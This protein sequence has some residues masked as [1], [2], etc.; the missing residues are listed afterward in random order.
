MLSAPPPA[1]RQLIRIDGFVPVPPAPHGSEEKVPCPQKAAGSSKQPTKMPSAPRFSASL[2]SFK[3]SA[4]LS[5][6]WV[7]D[8]MVKLPFSDFPPEQ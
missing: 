1:S 4:P 5:M 8:S 3:I 2:A 7:S 6:A